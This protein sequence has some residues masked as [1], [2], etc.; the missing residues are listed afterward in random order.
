MIAFASDTISMATA[1]IRD[2][3]KDITTS[4]EAALTEAR[5][6]LKGEPSLCFTFPDIFTIGT[7][8]LV[9]ELQKLLGGTCH[10]WRW[11]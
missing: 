6:K 4:V 8:K 3:S 10:F 11:L 7:V 1:V 9:Q 5:S 2:I